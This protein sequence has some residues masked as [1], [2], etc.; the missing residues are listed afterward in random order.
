MSQIQT[1]SQSYPRECAP[2]SPASRLAEDDAHPECPRAW[3]CALYITGEN[4]GCAMVYNMLLILFIVFPPPTQV[5]SQLHF[6]LLTPQCYTIANLLPSPIRPNNLVLMP[7]LVT[8]LQSA[9]SP[10][11]SFFP[12][13]SALELSVHRC[14]PTSTLLSFFFF[15]FLCA[16]PEA[17]RFSHSSSASWVGVG[18]QSGA[19]C[20][21]LVAAFLYIH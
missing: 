16:P 7:H 14:R 21:V 3:P 13:F 10:R 4:P 1:W 12:L 9:C 11:L 8:I 17:S 5:Y 20:S 6:A 15:V 18:G 2:F 19:A